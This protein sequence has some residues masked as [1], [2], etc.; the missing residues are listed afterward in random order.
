MASLSED[1]VARWADAIARLHDP[2]STRS[3]ER[4]ARQAVANLWSG[5]GYCASPIHSR[6]SSLPSQRGRDQHVSQNSR[7]STVDRENPCG[8]PMSLMDRSRLRQPRR[9]IVGRSPKLAQARVS[10]SG[11]GP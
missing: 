9:I 10:W 4:V 5:F 11:E 3:G 1:D 8:S 2:V 7:E 6:L